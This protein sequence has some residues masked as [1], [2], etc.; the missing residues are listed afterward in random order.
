MDNRAGGDD[1][2]VHGSAGHQRGQRVVAAHRRK[3]LGGRGRKHVGVDFL[4]GVE[5]RGAAA[6]R[7]AVGN[8]RSQT[9]LHELCGALHDQFAVVRPGAESR[10]ARVLPRAAGSGRRR[11]ATERAG[12]FGGHVSAGETRDGVRGLRHGR[13]GGTGPGA[14]VGWVDHRQ[15]HVALD[16]PDQHPGGNPVA[17]PDIAIDL[18]PA[19]SEAETG[20]CE[21]RLHRLRADRAGVGN[22][23]GRAR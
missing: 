14:N 13:G 17:H 19:V 2:D 10:L 7:L 15:F 6:E 12:D 18:R 8:V 5:R 20:R 16:F 4:P 21:D 3:P 9:V 23:A 11:P 22:A 1:G